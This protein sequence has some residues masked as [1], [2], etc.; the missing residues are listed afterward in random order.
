MTGVDLYICSSC[1]SS[2]TLVD[3]E[4][5]NQDLDNIDSFMASKVCCDLPLL[6]V[7]SDSPFREW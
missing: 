5:F 2:I 7:I 3:S 6:A 1:R 4:N